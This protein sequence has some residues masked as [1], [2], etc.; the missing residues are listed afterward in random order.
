V[1]VDPSILN[2]LKTRISHA[3]WPDQIPG[4]EWELGTDRGYLQELAEYW[5]VDRIFYDCNSAE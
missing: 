1:N 3:R 2:D 5:K 4:K